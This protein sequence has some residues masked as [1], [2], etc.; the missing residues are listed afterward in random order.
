MTIRGLFRAHVE[1]P[2]GGTSNSAASSTTWKA[3]LASPKLS[4][5]KTRSLLAQWSRQ[6][7]PTLR[8]IMIAEHT[9]ERIPDDSVGDVPLNEALA[10]LAW[11]HWELVTVEDVPMVLAFLGEPA[12]PGERELQEWHAYWD[13]IDYADRAKR[14]VNDPTYIVERASSTG[15]RLRNWLLKPNRCSAATSD[16]LGSSG[17]FAK[18]ARP[19]P[20]SGRATVG[21]TPRLTRGDNSGDLL[22]RKERGRG[23]SC[24]RSGTRTTSASPPCSRH[25]GEGDVRVRRGDRCHQ[26]GL[27]HQAR[28][29]GAANRVRLVG[30]NELVAD[31]RLAGAEAGA[32]PAEGPAAAAVAVASRTGPCRHLPPGAPTPK[33]TPAAKTGDTV[34][35]AT[36]G[37]LTL[38]AETTSPQRSSSA[39]PARRAAPPAQ[40]ATAHSTASSSGEAS[41]ATAPPSPA[42]PPIATQRVCPRKS[43]KVERLACRSTAGLVS[44]FPMKSN[45]RGPL[46]V[47]VSCRKWGIA[48]QTLRLP[49]PRSRST[50][51]S[52]DA[53]SVASGRRRRGFPCKRDRFL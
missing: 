2:E 22:I 1:T 40:P 29:L 48:V 37:V 31:P 8:V 45:R 7:I 18:R 51:A 50:V 20:H 44:R 47:T 28:K 42:P 17:G 27:H 23:R 3:W 25:E 26:Q 4:R 6:L 11:A 10:K 32:R 49:R 9:E 5:E 15:A 24:R 53:R 30:R 16:R 43:K 38:G 12:Q 19:R 41:P 46:R 13:A 21:R 35:S 33:Q 34:A 52:Q 39:S 14:L 36:L